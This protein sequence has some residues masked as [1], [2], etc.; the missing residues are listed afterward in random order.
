METEAGGR[1]PGSGSK[2]RK[3]APLEAAAEGR[4]AG[5]QG[6]Q[7][8]AGEDEDEG[9]AEDRIS[10]IPDAVLGEIV[11]LLPTKDG[12]RT[13]V[14]ASR[15]RHLWRSAPLNLDC[16][17]LLPIPTHHSDLDRL[18]SRILAAHTGPGRRLC[19]PW[20]NGRKAAKLESWLRS[21]ALDNLEELEFNNQSPG[22]LSRLPA[23]ASRFAATLRL[24][25]IE[26]CHLPDDTVQSLRFPQLKHLALVKVVISEGALASLILACPAMECLLLWYISG[27]R[28]AR[29]SSPRIR[30][31]GVIALVGSNSMGMP[32]LDE[33]VIENAPSLER[34]LHFNL[35]DDLRVSV[36][37]A[38]KLETFCIV[39]NDRFSFGRIVEHVGADSP[40]TMAR[41]VKILAFSVRFFSL[42]MIV[43]FMRLFP[44]LEK[45]YIQ[46]KCNTLFR[47]MSRKKGPKNCWRRKH[48]NLD[49]TCLDTH[50]KT[51]VLES[52]RGVLSEVN[53]ATFF[54]L[55]ARVLESMTFQ[56]KNIDEE[57]IAKQQ[58]LLQVENRAS[59]GIEFH[60]TDDRCLRDFPDI[61][62][63]RDLDLTDPFVR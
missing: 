51:I 48:R 55:N 31:I 40:T 18:V 37:D 46:N 32:N 59:R 62:H 6:P 26:S 35:R 12:A 23:S 21:P 57:F 28:R 33:L 9:A 2:K 8:G 27:V 3:R 44:C 63:V 1:R 30:S 20:R 10:Q 56:V 41:T 22:S 54:V 11:S 39:Q 49:I 38:P 5:N 45:L 61:R 47:S 13:Q 29:I 43:D 50:L 4:A 17:G 36:I 14:L 24:V 58:K 53:F 34:L 25:R 52:Y 7:P 19:V 42:D 15:W 60:F 16:G